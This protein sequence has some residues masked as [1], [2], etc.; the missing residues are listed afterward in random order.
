MCI[1]GN[2]M[3]VP[4]YLAGSPPTGRTHPRTRRN[5]SKWSWTCLAGERSPGAP[6]RSD[7]L[8][9]ANDKW[10]RVR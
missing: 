6:F 4:R 9:T 2:S 1:H 8:D 3:Y 7:W 5:S 10:L